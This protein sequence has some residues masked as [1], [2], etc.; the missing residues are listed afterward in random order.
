MNNNKNTAAALGQSNEDYL[1]TLLTQL[2]HMKRAGDR[3]DGYS[4][5]RNFVS[6]T[7]DNTEIKGWLN[8]NNVLSTADFNKLLKTIRHEHEI[9]AELG[10]IPKTPI[11]YVQK[12][13]V[14]RDISMKIDGSLS[15]KQRIK[16]GDKVITAEDREDREVDNHYRLSAR[17]SLT[18]QHLYTELKIHRD[19]LRMG[20]TD[21]QLDTALTSWS[22][23][24]YAQV[25]V[26][27][28]S[29]IM[30]K[31]G[32]ATG[33]VG[34]A[35]WSNLEAAVF[36]VTDTTPGFAIQV[37]KKFIWQVKRKALSMPVT[38]HLMPVFVGA[39][40]VGKSTFLDKLIAPLN[41][42]H[43]NVGFD[44]ISDNRNSTE[45]WR[46][47]VL[48]FEEMSG[49]KRADMN[50]VK[51]TLTASVLDRRVLG[52]NRRIKVPQM[53]TFIGNS[54]FSLGEI[55]RD[56]TGVRRFAELIHS[57]KPNHAVVNETDFLLLWQSV[58]ERGEDPSLSIMSVL[59][60][61]QEENRNQSSVEQWANLHGKLFRADTS[62][63]NLYEVYKEWEMSYASREALSL[64]NFSKQMKT[65]AMSPSFGWV[66]TRVSAGMKYRY[67]G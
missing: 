20:F 44:D 2:K 41:G 28:I 55:I 30:Y 24:A 12:Y 42:A 57:T 25:Y 34:E 9:M 37:L 18:S 67:V 40:G 62:S 60:A 50:S 13:V 54:N 10:F 33:P 58:D 56:T 35:M 5:V 43:A 47:L 61:Q 46:N 52:T 32:K 19:N 53:A 8:E 7:E 59:K 16:V 29:P 4:F 1:E 51:S 17:N 49:A 39:Q 23:D 36:D 14:A 45:M 31:P 6:V 22:D 26:D 38:N 3:I 66:G 48:V 63:T 64:N 65:L 15:R 21:S 27:A 11:E